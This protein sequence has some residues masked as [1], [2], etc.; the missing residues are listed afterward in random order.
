MRTHTGTF[1]R[2]NS[3]SRGCFAVLHL[4]LS[5][6]SLLSLQQLLLAPHLQPG[7]VHGR[8]LTTFAKAET[9]PG[10]PQETLVLLSGEPQGLAPMPAP[11][12][13]GCQSRAWRMEP[14]AWRS[15]TASFEPSLP[16]RVKLSDFPAFRLTGNRC[17]TS[18]NEDGS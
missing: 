18:Y 11:T 5:V 1:L 13:V 15:L 12:L 16:C 14:Q 4:F 2:V 6:M 8:H 9:S 3:I 10:A 17:S 7:G